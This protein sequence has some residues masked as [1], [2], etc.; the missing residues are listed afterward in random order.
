M[1]TD[2][3]STR[4]ILLPLGVIAML[5]AGII[6]AWS[7]LKMPLATEFG[8]GAAQLAL[9]FTLTMTFF[10]IGGFLGSQITKKIGTTL[11]VAASGILT[12]LGFILTGI[13]TGS[14]LLLYVTYA[15]MAGLGIGIS[16]NVIIS[17]VSA[18]FPDKKG[19]CSGS[20]MMGFGA[21]SLI[22][23]KVAEKMFTSPDIG[24]RTTFIIIGITL[25]AVLTV[26]SFFMKKPDKSLQFP[27]AKSVSKKNLENFEIKDLTP[28]EMI[29]RP[30]FY[31]AFFGLICLTAVGSSVISFAK[32]LALFVGASADLST[33]LVG[34]LAI[35]NGI[36]RI[37][38]GLLFDR[39]GRKKTM[40]TA[41]LTT[42]I[43][44]CITLLA[45]VLKSVPICIL[46][47]CLTGMSYGTSPTVS[48]AFTSAF[49]GA[50]HFPTNLSIMNFNLIGSS[51]MATACGS[52]LTTSG[53]YSAP[54]ALLLGLSLGALV[55]NVLIKKP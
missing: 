54:F 32:D 29:K 44:A 36:G 47:L 49:Y 33:T 48:A 11:S 37:L 50:K 8:W 53:G 20:L 15:L 18:W 4:K 25:T 23:G 10:C 14:I 1:K 3:L 51:L 46:G 45:I 13:S 55:L 16:Y 5:F 22:L 40:L 31:Q 17:T 42:V 2:R 6:Y 43:A 39:I 35:F 19:L 38:T 30:S 12:G 27:A 34:V 7:I 21:S 24:W 52:L 26:T 41:N 9:N 28:K